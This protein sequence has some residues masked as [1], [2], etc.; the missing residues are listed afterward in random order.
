[1]IQLITMYKTKVNRRI[2]AKHDSNTLY[3]LGIRGGRR[4]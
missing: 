4:R 3:L 1:M 2:N